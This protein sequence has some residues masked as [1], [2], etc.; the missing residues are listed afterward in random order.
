MRE[1]ERGEKEKKIKMRK[2]EERE[3]ERERV[4]MCVCVCEW[5]AVDIIYHRDLAS[6]FFFY[7]FSSFLER[8]QKMAKRWYEFETQ[9][10][11]ECRLF[12]TKI[13]RVTL[14]FF[15]FSSLRERIELNR[16]DFR[17]NIRMKKK[18]K[19][20]RKFFYFLPNFR[21]RFRCP[22]RSCIS[23]NSLFSLQSFFNLFFFL[24]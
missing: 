12:T 17:S 7:P 4:F 11:Y 15:P 19:D 1:R 3:R 5:Q 8:T 18:R 6:N 9:I 23:F 24:R 14:S 20:G 13:N 2:R 10:T 22:N 16:F 21:L